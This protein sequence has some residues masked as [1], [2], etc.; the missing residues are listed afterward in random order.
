PKTKYADEWRLRNFTED[1]L[2]R[3][4]ALPQVSSVGVASSVPFAGFGASVE[5]QPGDRPAPQ[6]GERF[7]AGFY[8]V[9]PEYFSTMQ[10]GLVKRRLFRIT[11]GPGTSPLALINQTMAQQLW[12]NQD[13]IGRELRFGERHTVATV[14]GVVNDIKTSSLRPLPERQIYV[15]MA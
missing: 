12:P 2:A 4:R 11:D 3:L 1:V 5:V 7:G 14:V 15:A 9:S 6:P 8:A 10:I 13:P